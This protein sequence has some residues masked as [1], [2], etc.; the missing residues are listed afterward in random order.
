MGYI[1]RLVEERGIRTASIMHLPKV[2]RKIR[3][4]RM[5]T[6]EAPLGLTFGEAFEK[7]KQEKILLE[8]LDLSITGSLEEERPSKYN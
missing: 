2:A 7:E 5:L 4:P 3:P 6:T 1:Q 8:L